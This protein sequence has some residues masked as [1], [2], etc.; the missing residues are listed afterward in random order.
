MDEVN[1]MTKKDLDIAIE[2]CERIMEFDTRT[3]KNPKSENG[4]IFEKVYDLLQFL[5]QLQFETGTKGGSVDDT[6]SRQWLMECVNDGWIKFDTEK[7][8]NRFIHLVR[9]IAP[10]AQPTLYG[11]D[12]KNLIIF[13]DAVRKKEITESEIENFVRN[14]RAAWEYA[15]EEF[16]RTQ[17]EALD[18]IM[19]GDR[20]EE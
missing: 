17:K 14:A 5:R 12:L 2:K 13:A 20:Y 8:E 6:I 18:S 11:Y 3:L 7:D 19:R 10:S 4:Y 15:W 1:D 9:D 16:Q